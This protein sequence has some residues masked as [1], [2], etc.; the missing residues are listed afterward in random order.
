MENNRIKL[1]VVDAHTLGY[2]LPQIPDKV[3]ILHTSILKGSPYSDSSAIFV[4]RH[5]IRLASAEDFEDFRCV[6]G[7]FENPLEYEYAPTNL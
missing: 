2:I 5:K 4:S 7:S 6:F 1:V 3:Q